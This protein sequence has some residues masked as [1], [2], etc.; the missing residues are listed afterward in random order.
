MNPCKDQIWFSIQTGRSTD[1]PSLPLIVNTC[2]FNEICFPP[3]SALASPKDAS[4]ASSNW[5]VS[6]GP[7]SSLVQAEPDDD[8][9]ATNGSMFHKRM[10]ESWAPEARMRGSCRIVLVCGDDDD[11]VGTGA[12]GRNERERTQSSWPERVAKRTNL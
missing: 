5:S 8:F 4:K 7:S 10:V 1:L 11:A 2:L 6:C 12:G 3:S 9:D